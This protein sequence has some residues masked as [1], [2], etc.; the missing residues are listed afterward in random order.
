MSHLRLNGYAIPCAGKGDEITTVGQDKRR[1]FD[2]TLLPE[3]RNYKRKWMFQSKPLKEMDAL[4]LIA[5]VQGKGQKWEYADG[6]SGSGLKA[7]SDVA[8]YRTVSSDSVAVYDENGVLDWAF[9]ASTGTAVAFGTATTNVL[10]AIA[11]NGPNLTTGTD[12]LG[13]TGGFTAIATATLASTTSHKWQGARSLSITPAATSDGARTAFATVAANATV[14]ASVYVRANGTQSATLR[15]YQNSG[16]PALL[17]SAPAT[18]LTAN[19][20]RRIKLTAT[21]T[22]GNTTCAMQIEAANNA[23]EVVYCD[24]FQ[25]EEL[26]YVT[27][28]VTSTRAAGGLIHTGNAFREFKDATVNFWAKCATTNPAAQQVLMA[29][30]ASGTNYL[31]FVRSAATNNLRLDTALESISTSSTWNNNWHMVTGVARI[32]PESGEYGLQ[33]YVDGSSVATN[34]TVT[35]YTGLASTSLVTAGCF[36]AAGTQILNNAAIDSM[37]VVPYAA[38]TTE[39]AAWYTYQASHDLPIL[40]ADGDFVTETSAS[41]LGEVTSVKNVP[42]YTT[43]WRGNGRVVEF[44]LEEI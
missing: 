28:W 25:I 9:G 5:L 23:F 11:T 21:L 31:A 26:A 19:V 29:L 43:A 12:S 2:G 20:W 18:T 35:G 13:T 3:V 41:V 14:T 34:A 27:P 6:Y 16:V 32:N 17:A 36:G 7:S 44:T 33:L 22:G 15:I 24:G 8:A 1:A 4:A 37:R 42:H 30:Y 38:T 10:Y 39:I 40:Y